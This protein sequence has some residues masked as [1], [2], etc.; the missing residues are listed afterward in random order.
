MKD[1]LKLLLGKTRTTRLKFERLGDFDDINWICKTCKHGFICLREQY[2]FCPGCGLKINWTEW[3]IIKKTF[4]I[5]CGK[6]LVGKEFDTYEEAL[7]WAK[8]NYRMMDK[9]EIKE[10]NP[11]TGNKE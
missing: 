9:V 10:I 2:I 11:Q 6:I 1:P 3:E 7:N 5:K 4:K 8:M